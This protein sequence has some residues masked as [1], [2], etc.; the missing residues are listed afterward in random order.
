MLLM[1]DERSRSQGGNN[2]AYAQDTRRAGW[3]GASIRIRPSRT[4]W[5][6]C[7]PCAGAQPALRRRRFF[8]GALIDPD[9][10]LRDVHWLSPEGIEMEVRHWSDD[11]L[12]VFGMQI[13]TTAT[14]ASAC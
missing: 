12:Q 8:T 11:G 4:S 6:T 1:G 3:T 10:P 9:E 5:P 2:N 13:A 14:R 7:W